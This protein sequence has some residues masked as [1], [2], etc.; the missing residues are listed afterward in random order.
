[1]MATVETVTILFTDLVGSTSL[2]SQVGPVR[3]YELRNE[4][5]SI[6]SEAI[7]QDE[8]ARS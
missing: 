6:L 3:A 8:A 2:E 4:H 5:F 7:E 1:M